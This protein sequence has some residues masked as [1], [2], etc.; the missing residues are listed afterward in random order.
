MFGLLSSLEIQIFMSKKALILLLFLAFMVS[1]CQGAPASQTVTETPAGEASP[2][3][4]QVKGEVPTSTPANS[5]ANTPANTATSVTASVAT[6]APD[7]T[8]PPAT[9]GATIQC[10]VVSQMPTPGP[11]EQSIFPPISASDWVTGPDTAAVTFTEYG[12]FQ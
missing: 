7:S 8:Q 9:S 11:T 12:D 10:T 2:P 3:E 4:T 6:S 5:P 1:A